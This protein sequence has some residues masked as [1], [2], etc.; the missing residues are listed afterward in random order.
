MS[1]C[2]RP[3]DAL[4]SA[5][6]DELAGRAETELSRHVRVCPHCSAK[7]RTILAA[8]GALHRDL[9]AGRAV[10]AVGKEALIAR[11]RAQPET[12]T[13]RFAWRHTRWSALDEWPSLRAAAALGAIAVAAITVLFAVGGREE[14]LPGPESVPERTPKAPLLVDAP[15]YNVAVIP[16]T[17]PDITIFWFSKENDDAQQADAVRDGPIA[18]GP[19]NGL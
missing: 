18:I 1:S 16:T 5:E 4:L 7:A 10:D 15:G 17:N 19:G 6:P 8:I 3:Q 14:T 9:D 11:A 13:R 2:D 12:S